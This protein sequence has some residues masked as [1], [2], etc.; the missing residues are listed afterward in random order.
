MDYGIDEEWM[1][2]HEYHHVSVI[3]QMCGTMRWAGVEK[4]LA[5][6]TADN[7]WWLMAEKEC[8]KFNSGGGD[9][10]KFRGGPMNYDVAMLLQTYQLPKNDGL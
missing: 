2:K 3:G 7:E 4:T 8:W 1:M 5:L 6:I 10:N 9:L